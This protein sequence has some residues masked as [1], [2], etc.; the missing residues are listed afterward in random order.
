[1]AVNYT[2]PHCGTPQDI[3]AGTALADHACRQCGR[4]LAETAVAQG[5]ARPRARPAEEDEAADGPDAGRKA[6][7]PPGRVVA[8]GIVWLIFGCLSVGG[9]AVQLLLVFAG[10][11]LAAFGPGAVNEAVGTVCGAVPAMLVGAVFVHVGLQSLRG[12]APAV[13]GNGIGSILFGV[14]YTAVGVVLL[15]TAAEVLVLTA[16]FCFFLAL[17]LYAAGVLALLGRADY[18]TF[19]R[20]V[21]RRGPAR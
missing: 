16:V 1:M 20:A 3:E 8:A 18:K 17:T 6:H 9:A 14:L 15:V 10:P 13:L 4:P 21:Q 11:G 12:T 19:R 5:P 7:R 2:C